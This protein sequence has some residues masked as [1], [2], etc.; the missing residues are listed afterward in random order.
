MYQSVR[1]ALQCY[2]LFIP[3]GTY[4]V[5]L[6][7]NEP[8]YGQAG[9]R[10][11]GVKVQGRQVIDGLDIF[12]RVGKNKAMDL[13][14][15]GVKVTDGVLKIDFIPQTEYPWIAG[16]AVEGKTDA[17]AQSPSKAYVRKIN[18]GGGKYKDYEADP[19]QLPVEDVGRGRTMPVGDFYEDFARASFGEAVAKEAGTILAQ[20][21]GVHFPESAGW[22]DGPGNIKIVRQPW[23]Q[24]KGLY[25]FVDELAALRPRVSTTGSLERFDYWLNTFRYASA[26]AEAGC[27]RGMLDVAMEALKAQKDPAKKKD[28]AA[29]ALAIRIR[30][31]R[32]WEKMLTFQLA[33]TDTPGEM[34][35]VFQP[36]TAQPRRVAFHHR[37]DEVLTAALGGPLPQ[38]AQ[39]LRLY[40]GPP[41]IIVPNRAH[42]G[43]QGRV[44]CDQGDC[45]G[46]QA[47]PIG[48]P[49]LAGDGKGAVSVY[50]GQAWRSGRVSRRPPAG[51]RRHRV[52]HR[53]A[54]GRRKEAGLARRTAHNQSDRDC[55]P[56]MIGLS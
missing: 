21:D 6:K 14:F 38:D 30:L 9:Q 3:N 40:A 42:G 22:G 17:S 15:E 7:F 25:S 35:T 5:T 31:A 29:E 45:P 33:A 1:Y 10:V 55:E 8:F 18:I 54:D 41:R 19:T 51:E 4:T 26:M 16:I 50:R 11:F 24:V 39:L 12:A 49:V 20:I 32:T 2:D 47:G 44:A 37:D 27:C 34:G 52:L 46:Q 48:H 43:G 56:R 28:Q 53:G 36:R 13:S 23:E